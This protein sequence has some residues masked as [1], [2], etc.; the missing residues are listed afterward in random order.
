MQRNLRF[1]FLMLVILLAACAE[2]EDAEPA[3]PT[4][5]AFPTAPAVARQ[6]Y[7]VQRGD[8]VELLEFT[9]RWEPRDQAQ[10][11]FDVDGTVRQVY[12]RRGDAVTE[13]EV[14][15][16]FDI[17]QLEEQLADQQLALDDALADAGGGDDS[18]E[19]A[20]RA[21]FDAQLALQ[22]LEDDAP[23]SGVSASL[24]GVDDARDALEDAE[25]NYRAA[26][27]S[28]APDGSAV[29]NAYD[30]LLDARDAV[31]DAEL[32]YAQSAASVGDEI[33]AYNERLI[34]AQNNVITAEQN[35]QEALQGGGSSQT[36]RQIRDLRIEIQRI[37]DEINRSTLTSPIDGVVLEVT[38]NQ[39]DAVQA[40]TSVMTVGIPEPR[41]V[42]AN[43]PIAQVQRLSA[44]LIG[45]CNVINRP[46]TAVQCR[47]RQIPASAQDADQ[48]TR[49]AAD[50]SDLADPGAIIEVAMPLQTREDVLWLQPV[51]IREF[52]GQPFVLL[53]TPEGPRRTFIEIGLQTDDR[54]EIVSGL[55]EG[56]VVIGN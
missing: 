52:Q 15:A 3:Q 2:G 36:E 37:E 19:T 39:G 31:G 1:A 51:A 16:D 55:E 8:V 33:E 47:V 42:I 25:D 53:E 29:K 11:S 48:S 54:V 27:A 6:T 21:L 50:M 23:R 46:E 14:L 7:T 24:G 26:L 22:R 44:G 56:D 30:A 13:G 20:Q 43:I 18:I 32:N 10:L 35:L 34:D 28:N 4:S 38:I 5:T 17:E 49:I 45:V 40:F 9:G 41:E 12:V